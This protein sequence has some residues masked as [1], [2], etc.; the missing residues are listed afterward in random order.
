MSDIFSPNN[1]VK[2]IHATLTDAF[3]AIPEGRSHAV[4]FD[5]TYSEADG[6]EGRVLFVQRAPDGW[7]VVLEGGYSVPE[8]VVG[9]V[10][11]AK[12]W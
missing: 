7:N 3:T 10:A 5:G 6:P 8:G 1:T 4:I 2:A 9:R 12:S 11:V